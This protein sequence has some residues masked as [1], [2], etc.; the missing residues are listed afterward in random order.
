MA[1]TYDPKCYE[2]AEHFLDDTELP[3]KL[4]PRHATRL[5][6]ILQDAVEDFL[7]YELEDE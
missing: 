7:E 5:A 2:L 4:K 1:S 3:D 6:L